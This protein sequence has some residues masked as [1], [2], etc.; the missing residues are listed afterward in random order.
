MSHSQIEENYLKAIFKLSEA[1]ERVSTSGI[2]GELSINSASVS[3][4]IKKMAKKGW[5]H[6]E[7]YQ[8]VELTETGKEIA[9]HIIR[10]HRL[11]EVFLVEKLGFTWSEVHEL[12]EQLEHIKSDELV[13]RLDDFLGNPS[14][15]PHGDPIPDREGSWPT[16]PQI[17]LVELPAGASSRICGVGDDSTELLDY[18]EQQD[19]LLGTRVTVTRHFEFDGSIELKRH[20]D[21][22]T[23]SRKVAEH[24]MVDPP[25]LSSRVDSTL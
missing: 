1:G 14:Y 5:L 18:L 16:Q 15:D 23:V 22:V 6:Y 19:L 21:V 8:G 2:A 17:P 20:G 3:D 11:W 13:N 9:T 25:E 4:M 7:K 12:A 10:K 24:I